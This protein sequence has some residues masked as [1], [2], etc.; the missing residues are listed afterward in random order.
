M[1]FRLIKADFYKMKR[2]K[3]YMIHILVPL[4]SAFLL[5]LYCM[6][7][8]KDAM[9]KILHYSELESVVCPIVIAAVS[10]FIIENEFEASK[11]KEMLS[12]KCGKSMCLLSKILVLLIMFLFSLI[13]AMATLIISF[14]TIFKSTINFKLCS[15]IVLIIFLTNIFMYLFHIFLSIQFG[16]G[17]SIAVGMGET[18]LSALMITGLGDVIWKWIPCSWSSRIVSYLGIAENTKTDIQYGSVVCFILT[19]LCF[20]LLFIWFHFFE[21]VNRQH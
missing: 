1:L 16:S 11:F 12:L 3:F 15:T 2:T 20:I 5:G 21:N 14:K 18:L 7:N 4:L 9:T 17:I 8:M 6:L 10:S 19:T 13:I